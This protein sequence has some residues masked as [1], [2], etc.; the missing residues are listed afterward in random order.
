MTFEQAIV[1]SV[2]AYFKGKDPQNLMDV[3]EGKALEDDA[4]ALG[5]PDAPDTKTAKYTRSFMEELE[6]SLLE[7]ESESKTKKSKAATK[8]EDVEDTE[9]VEAAQDA[10]DAPLNGLLVRPK[11]KKGK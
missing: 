5:T 11:N 10:E 1:K 6:A 9:D 8:V 2:R 4:D 3:A 7:P